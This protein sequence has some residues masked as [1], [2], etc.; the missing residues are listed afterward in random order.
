L[1]SKLDVKLSENNL[2]IQNGRIIYDNVTADSLENV[3]PRKDKYS[4]QQSM[5]GIK[6]TK[7]NSQMDG[8]PGVD[9]ERGETGST[10]ID[11]MNAL[12]NQDF[13]DFEGRPIKR[14]L[15]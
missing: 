4:R 9:R 13:K 1:L 5:T 10:M 11:N 14:K 6:R 3:S 7:K 12:V 8:S 2:R 15:D